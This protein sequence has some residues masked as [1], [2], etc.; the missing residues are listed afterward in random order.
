MPPHT[1]TAAQLALQAER[2]AAKEAKKA[3]A[4]ALAK[5]QGT[6]PVVISEAE[7]TKFLNREWVNLNRSKGQAEE[8]AS[9]RVRLTTWNVG[10]HSA[11]CVR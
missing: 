11:S 5:E 8:D 7:R 4:K 1:L 9:R 3:A 6:A 10:H 2:K